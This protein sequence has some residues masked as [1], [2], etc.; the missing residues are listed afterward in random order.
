MGADK[1]VLPAH[2]PEGLLF[3]SIP[4][5]G[6]KLSFCVVSVGVSLRFHAYWNDVTR[7]VTIRGVAVFP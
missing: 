1:A 4:P 7:G 3:C 6:V 5:F 2:G